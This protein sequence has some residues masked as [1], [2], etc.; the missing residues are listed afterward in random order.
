LRFE[1]LEH[2]VLLAADLGD[3]P[4]PL[5]AASHEAIGPTLGT[6]RDV[7]TYATTPGAGA[8][9][10]DD[11]GVFFGTLRIGQTGATI[12]V[13]VQ[14]APAGARLDAWWDFN[15]NNAWTADEQ[16][17]DN[18]AVVNGDNSVTFNIPA[19]A[20]DGL[21][22][23]RFR[24]ST[25]GD[26]AVGG[27]ALDGEVEDYFIPIAR[28][29]DATFGGQN[30][31]NFANA[32]AVAAA[33]IDGDGDADLVTGGNTNVYLHENVNG[34]FAAP[35]QIGSI[36]GDV[37]AVKVGDIDHDGLI[38]AL[39]LA[40]NGGLRWFEND[41]DGTFT[42]R[43]IS[44]SGVARA[45]LGDADGDGDLDLLVGGGVLG[46]AWS[47]FDGGSFG[48]PQTVASDMT[49]PT[50][51]TVVDFDG[52]GDADALASDSFDDVIAWFAADDGGPSFTRHVIST[53]ADNVRTATPADVDGDG[54]FDVLA[55][56][57]SARDLV[58]YENYGDGEFE[59]HLIAAAGAQGPPLL[60]AGD[61][62]GDGDTDLLAS[63]ATQLKWYEN[64]GLETFTP[65][66]LL[67]GAPSVQ[68][69]AADM[70]GDG[71]L[72]IVS[73]RGT[74]TP[75]IT[76]Q[77]Q[78][79]AMDFGD[80]PSPYRTALQ[81]NGARHIPVGPTL[82][83]LR[84]A[85]F[86]GLPA[87]GAAGEAED[88]GVTFG[89]MRIG[90]SGAMVTVNVQNAPAG[91]RLDAWLDFNADG[92]WGVAED[93]LLIGA[94]V[95]NG[96]NLFS[97]EVPAWANAGPTF[98]RFRLSTGGSPTPT[99][100]AAD[101]EVE[102]YA[103][104]IAGAAATT[105]HFAPRASLGVVS[106]A[107]SVRA[108]DFDRDGDVDL[109]TT[110]NFG[111]VVWRENV[112]GGAFVA[113]SLPPTGSTHANDAVAVDLDGDGDLDI[114]AV[115]YERVVWFENDGSFAFTL[116]TVL[117]IPSAN[118][119][120]LS[121]AVA[122]MD[123]D[124]DFDILTSD[125]G[126]NIRCFWNDGS[127]QF[128]F[129]TVTWFLGEATSVAAADVD[130]D[131]DVD[132]VA[133]GHGSDRTSGVQ[134]FSNIG[135]QTFQAFDVEVFTTALL[136]GQGMRTAVVVDMDDDGDLDI[137]AGRHYISVSPA[138]TSL[139]WYEQSPTHTFT[140][141][142]IDAAGWIEAVVAADFDGD[143]DQDLVASGYQ[144]GVDYF[145]NAGDA[146]FARRAL[147]AGSLLGEG[148][149]VAD[150]DGDG[151]LD[152]VAAMT[153]SG[154]LNWYENLDLGPADY[155][156]APPPF[157]TVRADSGAAHLA[158]GP[159]LGA[160]RDDEADGVPTVAAD[161]DAG[162]DG[163]ILP[164][165]VVG[166]TIATA[167]VNVQNAPVG[168]RLD[169][170]ID[171]N[172]DGS[173]GGA[174]EQIFTGAAVVEGD[175]VLAFNVPASTAVGPTFARFRLSTGGGLRTGGV[176]LDGEVED[177]SL[178]IASRAPATG[179]YGALAYFDANTYAQVLRTADID[180]DGDPDLLATNNGGS[181][182]ARV[183]WYENL[184]DGAFLRHTA[185][186]NNSNNISRNNRPVDFDGDGD[187]DVVGIYQSSIAWYENNGDESFNYRGIAG[188]GGGLGD[189]YELADMDG[190]GDL[191][192][193]AASSGAG[194]GTSTISLRLNDGQQG[195][196]SLIPIA[197]PYPPLAVGVSAIR[198]AD[199]DR[200]GDMDFVASFYVT[201]G[202]N[203]Y[204][205]IWFEN[206]SNSFTHHIVTT[207]ATRDVAAVDFDAD[208]DV[209]FVAASSPNYGTLNVEWW[210]NDG[211]QAFVK[212]SLGT[213][214]ASQTFTY[215]TGADSLAAV[216]VDGDGDVDA[217]LG[218]SRG[219]WLFRNNGTSGF[220]AV[221]ISQVVGL[222]P[223]PVAVADFDGDGA[224]EIV[225]ANS[226]FNNPFWVDDLPF[227]DYDRNGSVDGTDLLQWQRTL[228]SA[229]LPPGAGADG[230]RSGAIDHGDLEVWEQHVG[231]ALLPRVG[232]ANSDPFTSEKIDGADFLNWQR[233]LGRNFPP[234]SLDWEINGVV[235]GGDLAVWRRQF[236]AGLIPDYSW[237]NSSPS[238]PA[239][240][241]AAQPALAADVILSAP[242]TTSIRRPHA[243]ARRAERFTSVTT[244]R[245]AALQ[246]LALSLTRPAAPRG[247]G[248]RAATEDQ[249]T[250]L[251]P[252]DAGFA[253]LL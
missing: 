73:V 202:G 33:D 210:E 118:V 108:V 84:D 194:T 117:A 151:D 37:T 81:V 11:D 127:Q 119:A 144:R 130:R 176:A 78:L 82:G 226:T 30:V 76:W 169:A 216:D 91:A 139:I 253:E 51:V 218:D 153:G 62:D 114:V 162:D 86:I 249:S 238:V 241:P 77:R 203:S 80:A 47:Y 52:D 141:H 213:V 55:S 31:V 63:N 236:G 131:G 234:G 97:I 186:L 21:A 66:A 93:R 88:D 36:S 103:V 135:H 110:H 220:S 248:D 104:T 233:N 195:F 132:I 22:Y 128:A 179:E 133:A 72:D 225:G 192:A 148:L 5:P 157:R 100:A 83:A 61:F 106:S 70:D 18:L 111:A 229:A 2:R 125:T 90:Q 147:T 190:D 79:A 173:W 112:G 146:S 6:L 116:R 164:A 185:G 68:G 189:V 42:T 149:A 199:V 124:G 56:V 95:V 145:E 48:A 227:G 204:G 207:T 158:A 175:N 142:P 38:D 59:F 156:D 178:T 60:Q 165:L 71:R 96:D 28:S 35:S 13:Q 4:S 155:G 102:D 122:D 136:S 7:A 143:G 120:F 75:Q 205:V 154:G 1:R 231:E 16:I 191:D 8:D 243:P 242:G 246:T 92:D 134:W 198:A 160:V 29:E 74:T 113:R 166:Q 206:Q 140:P 138:A 181:T 64:D 196:T 239:V 69:I 212:R 240:E 187:I 25:A 201:P 251:E 126:R 209:D 43:T 129:A 208:G 163:V 214:T 168:A 177:Y 180:G 237:I 20:V 12:A 39:C 123:N 3:A 54:D 24:L 14:N 232:A 94:A 222:D 44:L 167:T 49:S 224:L 161:G 9:G 174:G 150:V 170:W 219:Y 152:P 171:F 137:V 217:V 223:A 193:I 26:L 57:D 221:S 183:A 121:T 15:R 34:V 215:S 41:G 89:P 107:E 50:A 58:W 172:R 46:V 53:S 99:G 188:I 184:Q 101:G 115:C 159:H 244:V 67:T 230:D 182:S 197:M 85:E 235:D 247:E 228:G 252:L 23:A 45:D 200:D 211:Q 105:G 65:H 98:A 27:A 40:T 32:F 245:D 109:V 19:T 10:A 17:A 87:V 250:P